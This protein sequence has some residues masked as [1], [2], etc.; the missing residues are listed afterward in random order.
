MKLLGIINVDFDVT[1]Q[2][3]F[4]LF[5]FVSYWRKNGSTMR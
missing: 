2:L 4:R 5:A 1:Y 3:L